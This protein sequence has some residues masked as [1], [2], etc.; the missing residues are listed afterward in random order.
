MR[1]RTLV[2]LV[3]TIALV[4]LPLHR[5]RASIINAGPAIMVSLTSQQSR[6]QR[7]ADLMLDIYQELVRM[8]YLHPAGI[9]LGPHNMTHLDEAYDELELDASVKYLY[10]ILPYVDTFGSGQQS[11]SQLGEF[12][13]FRDIDQAEQGRNPFYGSLSDPNFEDE[14]G[15][16][17]KPWV[18]P[19]TN[20]GNHGSV[21]LYDTR[22]HVIWIIDQEGWETTD[23]ALE[24]HPRKESESLNMNSFEHIMH[25]PAESVLRDIVQYYRSLEWIPGGGRKHRIGMGFLHSSLERHISPKWLA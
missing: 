3:F 14:E 20:L 1:L 6:L 7:V 9:Q 15:P 8:R 16:Y 25:R 23:P 11:F 21:M 19:L 4:G 2:F 17:M 22:R 18:T 10:S 24:D 5:Y 13:D 12:A